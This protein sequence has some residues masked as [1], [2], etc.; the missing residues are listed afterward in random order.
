MGAEMENERPALVEWA[1]TL[2]A[3]RVPSDIPSVAQ[4]AA[5]LLR[6]PIL[7]H[8]ALEESVVTADRQMELDLTGG[9]V[10]FVPHTRHS[11]LNRRMTEFLTRSCGH[12]FLRYGFALERRGVAFI[13]DLVQMPRHRA[14]QIIQAGKM[15]NAVEQSLA[16]H[17]LSFG[18]AA[19]RW[20]RPIDLFTHRLRAR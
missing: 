20:D 8:E 1:G 16:K 17:D 4:R 14:Q 18:M 6:R 19:P 10:G 7:A 5:T 3:P 9:L 15:F 12:V 11:L 2:S 13:G